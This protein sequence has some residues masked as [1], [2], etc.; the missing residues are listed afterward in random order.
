MPTEVLTQLRALRESIADSL[1]KDPR[2]LTLSALDKSIAEISGVV[3]ASGGPSDHPP[4]SSFELDAG[5]DAEKKKLDP[6]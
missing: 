5:H 6:S 4:L 1:R 3:S 2:F